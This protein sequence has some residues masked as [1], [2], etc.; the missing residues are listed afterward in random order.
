[1]KQRVAPP[2]S[3]VTDIRLPT[4]DRFEKNG[5]LLHILKAGVQP[6]FQLDIV[7]LA[8]RPYEEQKLVAKSLNRLLKEG[9][10]L[11]SGSQLAEAFDSLGAY[12]RTG[13]GMDYLSFSV[14]GLTRFA[15]PIVDL[16]SELLFDVD[17]KEEALEK[18]IKLQKNRLVH[19][20]Q[21]AEIL[22]YRGL[23][24]QLYGADHPYGYNSTPELYDALSLE[25][26][27]KHYQNYFRA[28]HCQIFLGGDIHEGIIQWVEEKILSRFKHTDDNFQAPFPSPEPGPK[29]LELHLPMIAQDSIRLGLRLFP[30]GHEDYPEMFFLS[31]LYGGFFGSRLMTELREK[32]GMT[33]HAFC[34][35]DHMKYDGFLMI[36]TEVS[37]DKTQEATDIIYKELDRLRNELVSEAELQLVRNYIIG[38]LLHYLDGPF[39]TL[40]LIKTMAL[41]GET[42]NQVLPFFQQ[43][44]N[45]RSEDLQIIAE[46]Y[47]DRGEIH[48]CIVRSK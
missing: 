9:T 34:Q 10:R 15:E 7:L 42:F 18:Y 3:E 36:G 46:R 2:I 22:S 17:L 21:N 41:S 38:N 14:Q 16:I 37:P 40:S 39:N 44:R 23:T 24:E 6:V 8:G 25:A 43:I 4:V 45:C 32:R 33:Y 48:R 29:S 1:M 5:A 47:F 31:T 13:G 26:L 20:L 35:T 30:R 12:F 27:N 11:K 28:D 19:D